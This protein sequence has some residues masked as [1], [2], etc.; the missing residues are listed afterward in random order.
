[1]FQ[2]QGSTGNDTRYHHNDKRN[3]NGLDKVVTNKFYLDIRVLDLQLEHTPTKLRD[4]GCLS[5]VMECD[6]DGHMSHHHEQQ[7]H[8]NHFGAHT[9]E[10]FCQLNSSSYAQDKRECNA[11]LH[12]PFPKH[13]PH[14]THFRES[15]YASNVWEKAGLGE[16]ESIEA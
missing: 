11:A 5:G 12:G 13:Y 6:C 15:E 4:V 10:W 1:M 8:S 16:E 14:F 7:Q 3:D 2:A 9:I